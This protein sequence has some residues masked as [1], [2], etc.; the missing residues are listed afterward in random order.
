MRNQPRDARGHFI[1]R[2]TWEA[3][4]RLARMPVPSR[5]GSRNAVAPRT[6]AQ[7]D[8]AARK[9]VTLPKVPRVKRA[10]PIK[11]DTTRKPDTLFRRG[12]EFE[13]TAKYKTAGKGEVRRLH[14]KIRVELTSSMTE[15]DARQLLGRA[16]QTGIV[17]PGIAVHWVDWRRGVGGQAV[18]GRVDQVSHD[19]LRNFY[20]I[21]G[22]SAKGDT[23]FA[24]VASDDTEAEYEEEP[25]DDDDTD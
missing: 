2:Q 16:V 19:E 15:G 8:A 24:P 11:R 22:G 1:N 12:Q 6:R 20:G 9:K 25:E 23:R 3:A 5:V 17:P 7:V 18:S 21:I 4:Y 14:L 10:K 13:L